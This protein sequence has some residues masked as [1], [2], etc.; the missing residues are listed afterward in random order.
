VLDIGCGEG[1]WRA[2]LRSLRPGIEYLG[3]DSSEYAI[4]RYGARATCVWRR[5]PAAE[6]R[7]RRHST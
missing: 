4:A 2:P 3:L 7:L 5:R 1:I 6:L